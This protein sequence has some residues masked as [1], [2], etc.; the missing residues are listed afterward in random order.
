[1]PLWASS[2][3]DDPRGAA[4]AGGRSGGRSGSRC[5]SSAS[6]VLETGAV[7]GQEVER[8]ARDRVRRQVAGGS[9]VD[10]LAEE[11]DNGNGGGDGADVT[12]DAG[13]ARAA[14]IVREA[15]VV[16]AEHGPGALDEGADLVPGRY[17]VR[18]S[19]AGAVSARMRRTRRRRS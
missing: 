14:S 9:D 13:I 3:R 19:G 5:G 12:P 10:V 11:V 4:P 17:S 2:S 7:A 18:R 6:R 15:A 16:A 1:M 8:Y